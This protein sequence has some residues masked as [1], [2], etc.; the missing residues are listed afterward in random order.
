MTYHQSS[1]V[2]VA[3]VLTAATVIV[4]GYH[5]GRAHAAHRDLRSARP[6]F[7]VKRGIFRSEARP[8]AIG[9]LLLF[10]TLFAAAWQ[11]GD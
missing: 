5:V 9:G 7:P 2:S 3:S 6:G 1:V 4:I 11:A 10:L 8:L